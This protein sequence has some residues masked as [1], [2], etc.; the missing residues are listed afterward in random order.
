MWHERHSLAR[1]DAAEATYIQ[2]TQ[3]YLGRLTRVCGIA[4]SIASSLDR[5]HPVARFP[6]TF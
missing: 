6:A 5:P 1:N 3:V 2:V 4:C